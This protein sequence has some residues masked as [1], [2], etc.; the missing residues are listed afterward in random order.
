MSYTYEYPHAA[1]TTDCVIF[2][3]DGQAMHVL[4]VE[5]G[6][7]PYKGYWALPG[8]FMQIDETVEQCAMRE[9]REETGLEGDIFLEQFHVYSDVHRDVRERVVT[10]AFLALVGKSDYTLVA[11]D[12][13][14]N[15]EWFLWNELPPLAFDHRDIIRDARVRLRE[16]MQ[17]KPLAF[18]LLDKKFRMSELQRLYELINDA[19]YDRRNFQR[20]MLASGFIESGGMA[21][22]NATRPAMLWSFDEEAFDSRSDSNDNPFRL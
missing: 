3:Y 15:A 17:V 10:V 6:L 13:A 5:R 14:A 19:T 18:R 16:M 7:D 8:G 21:E 4:L 11:G 22:V 12:D 20:K 9:L 2:G 1:L